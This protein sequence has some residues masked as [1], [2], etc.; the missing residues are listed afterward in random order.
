MQARA[1]GYPPYLDSW[2]KSR[3]FTVESLQRHLTG[4]DSKPLYLLLACV[5]AVLLISCA[6]VTNLQ[7]ARTVSRKHETAVRGALGASRI[8]LIRQFMAESLILSTLAATLGLAIAWVVTVLVRHAAT[9]YGSQMPSRATQVL[10]LPFGKLSATIHIDGWVLAFTVGLAVATTLISGLA[11]AISGSRADLRTALSSSG[12]HMSS[13]REQRLFRH[14]LLVI[15]V[16]LALV[17][18]AGAGLLVRS[19]VHVMSYD[20]GFK[21]P[22]I[23]SAIHS[24]CG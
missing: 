23:N 15:E 14:A 11:P 5:A 16:G 22:L 3:Q 19:F 18:L 9:F 6:N 20:S 13:S 1:K 4:D 2:A 21:E 7:L 8:R 10:R 24:Q 12:T 17:L